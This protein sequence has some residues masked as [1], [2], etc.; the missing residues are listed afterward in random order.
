VGGKPQ[1]FLLKSGNKIGCR[2][3]YSGPS[4]FKG[5]VG[6]GDGFLQFPSTMDNKKGFGK[7]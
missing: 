4:S 7:K 2:D 3:F 1:N 6:G 5:P